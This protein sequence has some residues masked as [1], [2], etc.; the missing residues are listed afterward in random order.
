MKKSKIVFSFLSILLTAV[1]LLFVF[2]PSAVA[3]LKGADAFSENIKENISSLSNVFFDSLNNKND[4]SVNNV[5][6]NS[7]NNTRKYVYAGG[8]PI[9]I[10]LYCDGVIIVGMDN[11]KTSDGEVNPAKKSGLQKGDIIKSINGKNVKSNTDVSQEIEKNKG[12]KIIF[13][14]YR[15]GKIQNIEFSSVKDKD[16]LFRAGLW[17]R[18]SSAGI[19]TLS[20]ITENGCFASLGHGVCDVDTGELLPLSDGVTTTAVITGLYKGYEGSAGELCGVLDRDE[21]GLIKYNIETGIYG[22]MKTED[23]KGL[24]KF[25]VASDNE[26]KKGKAQIITTVSEGETGY[27]D[28]EITDIDYKSAEHKNMVIKITDETLKEK[29]GGIIQGMSGS[30]II[31][32]GMIVGAVTH[33]FLNDPTGGYGIFVSSMLKE[34]EKI[35]E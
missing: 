27:Y 17:I 5:S 8:T 13:E 32:N 11:I 7:K 28:I 22:K 16:G 9:G 31:Q 25:P 19:G 1:F 24:T 14:I 12:N 4:G 34:T 6:E 35:T 33:V 3:D 29:T 26:I 23:F 15:N 21:T 20:F 10:K 2:A 30:P 18:D